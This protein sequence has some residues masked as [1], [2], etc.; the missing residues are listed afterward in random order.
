[1]K[2][3]HNVIGGGVHLLS[4]GHH[5]MTWMRDLADAARNMHPPLKLNKEKSEDSKEEISSE[6]LNESGSK[7]PMPVSIVPKPPGVKK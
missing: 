4:G 7:L 6:V 5:N 3:G 2:K 1:M